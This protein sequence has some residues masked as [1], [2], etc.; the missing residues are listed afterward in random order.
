MRFVRAFFAGL[1]VLVGCIVAITAVPVRWA[2]GQLQTD[3]YGNT[4]APLLQDRELQRLL[5]NTAFDAANE[6]GY[7]VPRQWKDRV[8]TQ[9]ATI[10][11]TAEA[12]QIWLDA[13]L[14]ARD[15]VVDGT[16][17]KI[18]VDTGDLIDY[19]R[20]RLKAHGINVPRA[21]SEADT[22]LTL[23]DSPEIAQARESVNLLHTLAGVLPVTALGV[24]GLAVLIARRRFVTLASAGFA[25]ALG[26]GGAMFALDAGKDQLL[27]NSAFAA[28]EVTGALV[29]AVYDAFG[30]SL[31]ADLFGALIAAVVAGAAGVALAI[32][33]PLLRRRS[34][35][36][37][38]AA[39]QRHE[40][41]GDG[42][43]MRPGYEQPY[44]QQQHPSA[45]YASQQSYS[46]SSRRQP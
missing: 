40:P 6:K 8:H 44:A 30:N 17:T 26:M 34:G 23:V 18:V 39:D 3:A 20:Q 12:R 36:A 13:N 28:D 15:L 38:H 35:A 2:D 5:A 16:G 19:V 41:R 11:A 42:A 27:S 24:L 33:V 43:P 9:M 14:A 32:V 37:E 29:T 10:L 25:V 4:V 45:P 7:A 1:L 31:R 46:E 21:P 22:R